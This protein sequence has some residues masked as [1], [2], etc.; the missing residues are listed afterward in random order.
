MSQQIG[1]GSSEKLLYQ[2]KKAIVR[3]TQASGT[4]ATTTTTTTLP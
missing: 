2:I 3:Q 1:W 4:P